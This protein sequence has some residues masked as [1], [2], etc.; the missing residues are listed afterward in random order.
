M[1]FRVLFKKSCQ[2]AFIICAKI[3]ADCAIGEQIAQSVGRCC[4]RLQETPLMSKKLDGPKRWKSGGC[5]PVENGI[6]P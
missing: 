6:V 2:L 3:L 5:S 4:G 1:D